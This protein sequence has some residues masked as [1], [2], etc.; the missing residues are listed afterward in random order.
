MR[1]EINGLSELRQRLA[2][3]R[4]DE[5]L[6]SALAEES[7]HLAEAVR[8]KLS[9]PEGAGSHDVPWVRTGALRDSIEATASGLQA[10]VGSNDPAAAPQELGTSRIPPRPFLAPTAAAEGEKIAHAIGQKIVGALRG[11][12]AT[13]GDPTT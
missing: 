2:Q 7:Q 10:A 11:Q 9:Q 4:V 1:I 13:D 6:A 8:Q 12:V 3:A 5:I